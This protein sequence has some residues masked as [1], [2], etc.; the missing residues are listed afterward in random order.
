MNLGREFHQT[1]G[2]I[3]EGRAALRI[4]AEQVLAEQFRSRKAL[5]S[6]ELIDVASD[7]TKTALVRAGVPH[8]DCIRQLNP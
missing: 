1:A 8:P 4:P 6:S 3:E 7:E 5:V 2:V